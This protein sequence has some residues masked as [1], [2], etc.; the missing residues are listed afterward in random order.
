[1]DPLSR[2]T[3]KDI[4]RTQLAFKEAAARMEAQLGEPED[5][6]EEYLKARLTHHTAIAKGQHE[7]GLVEEPI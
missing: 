4:I 3:A 5:V 2:A 1:M 7:L 6:A